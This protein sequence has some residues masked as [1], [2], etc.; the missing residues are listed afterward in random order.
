MRIV[1]SETPREAT[2]LWPFFVDFLQNG[3]HPFCPIIGLFPVFLRIHWYVEGASLVGNYRAHSISF[4]LTFS[5]IISFIKERGWVRQ[6]LGFFFSCWD[7]MLWPKAIWGRKGLF[8]STVPGA[9]HHDRDIMT[10]GAWS[11][12]SHFAHSRKPLA[13]CACTLLASFL[14]IYSPGSQ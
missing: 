8:P 6:C 13:M 10:V 12:Q 11:S 7:E 14:H 2:P 5:W 3:I 4:Y 1:P 9:A